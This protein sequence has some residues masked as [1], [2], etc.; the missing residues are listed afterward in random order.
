M[1]RRSSGA[2]EPRGRSRPGSDLFTGDLDV[3]LIG[4]GQLTVGGGGAITVAR[5]LGVHDFD[6]MLPDHLVF[7]LGV[8]TQ[9]PAAA[10]TAGGVVASDMRIGVELGPGYVPAAGD[11]FV[12]IAASG[13]AEGVSVTLPD[14]PARSSPRRRPPPPGWWWRSCPIR[15]SPIPGGKDDCNA[16]GIADDCDVES[17][18]SL[19]CN[20]NGI[21]DPC[22]VA[23]GSSFD[24]N[25]NGVPDECDVA[26]GTSDDCNENGVPDEC[27]AVGRVETLFATDGGLEQEFGSSVDLDG[28]YAIAG[29]PARWRHG[30]RVRVRAC[31]L[32]LDAIAPPRRQ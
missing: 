29:A 5:N 12:L 13:G 25:A 30:Y 27:E 22:D 3:G 11:T 16:N 21:P 8:P 14:V 24:C 10:I 20:A 26:D 23:N 9:W 1:A 28:M 15:V 7:E 6:P 4:G 32:R 18:L 2:S 19:D 31:R 17:G